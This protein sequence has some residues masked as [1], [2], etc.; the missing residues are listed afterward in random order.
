MVSPEDVIIEN[1]RNNGDG[2]LTFDVYVQ[3]G[4]DIAL[5]ASS[6]EQ[7]IEVQLFIYL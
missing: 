2:Q 1:V 4:A 7:A 3:Q 5:P 6:V